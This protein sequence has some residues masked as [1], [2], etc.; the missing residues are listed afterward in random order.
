M[1]TGP[2]PASYRTGSFERSGS[3]TPLGVEFDAQ[4]PVGMKVCGVSCSASLRHPWPSDSRSS[5]S[6]WT[7]DSDSKTNVQ[8]RPNPATISSD[9]SKSWVLSWRKSTYSTRSY[10]ATNTWGRSVYCSLS[11]WSARFVPAVRQRI[12]PSPFAN[13]YPSRRRLDSS[14]PR[15]AIDIS[16]K[17]RA[18][19]SSGVA[20]IKIG[21]CATRRRDW[22][23][24]N[25]D[26]CWAAGMTANVRPPVRSG[27][28]RQ[29]RASLLRRPGV[30][31]QRPC[32]FSS[33]TDCQST[34]LINKQSTG[35][36]ATKS[37]DHATRKEGAHAHRRRGVLR[38]SQV[39]V[40]TVYH[41]PTAMRFDSSPA[42]P[43]QTVRSQ[44]FDQGQPSR[45][46]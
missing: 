46:A 40:G 22:L 38:K 32:R 34:G 30:S 23:S 41:R 21:F 3:Q 19:D 36:R 35:L 14:R 12:A 11:L 6:C 17:C 45:L 25:G 1:V 31:R 33:R 26:S 15:L 27:Q 9:R 28:R 44:R 2:A 8:F 43:C 39:R 4:T 29:G 37:V 24:G 16:T 13:R 20:I 10:H 5:C 42:T 7:L 18:C